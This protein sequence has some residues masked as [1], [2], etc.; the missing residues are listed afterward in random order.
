MART[1]VLA[2]DHALSG[3]LPFTAVA[4]GL[5]VTGA[6]LLA[7]AV[8]TAGTATAPEQPPDEVRAGA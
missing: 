3:A 6:G 4:P 5:H 8:F 7:G 2:R 1:D